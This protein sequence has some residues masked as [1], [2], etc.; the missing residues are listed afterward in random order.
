MSPS[1]S[2]LSPWRL[3]TA[4]MLDW[5]DRHCRFFFRLLAPRARLYTEMVTTGPLV[6]GDAET[7]RAHLRFNPEEHPVALQLGGSEPDELAHA[8]RLAAAWG[9]DEINLNCGCPSERVQKGA[10]GA[11]LMREPALVADCVRA[12]RD[13]L[14]AHIPVTV[15]HRIGLDQATDYGFLRDFVGTVS[16]AGCSVFIIH[17]R[18]AVLQ[19]LSPKENREVPPLRYDHA[20]R[21]VSD[22]PA[23]TF[24]INGG[25]ATV[26]DVR[27]RLAETGAHGVMLGRAAYHDSYR[28][29]EVHATLFGG[30]PP[31]REAVVEAMRHYAARVMAETR[32][33]R[34]PVRLRDVARH[35]L[36]LFTGTAGGKRWRRM[37]SDPVLLAR[38]DPALLD[39]ALTAVHDAAQRVAPGVAPA[40][41]GPPAVA[42]VLRRITLEDR[43]CR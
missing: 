34:R 15:K 40:C 29:A 27:A 37:L 10:F 41:G 20:A 26:A 30:E 22:F 6:H 42:D 23:L 28:L 39:Q 13:A 36:G 18:H 19:G 25:M 21:L 9:Y 31:S 14:P 17:A 24:I 43:P 16:E 12:M 38:N 3:A 7:V 4:P 1:N 32:H 5:S 2:A 35:L 33:E 8:A 11:C